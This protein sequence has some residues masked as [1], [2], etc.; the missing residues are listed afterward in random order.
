MP[1]ERAEGLISVEDLGDAM[2]LRVGAQAPLSWTGRYAAEHGWA[3]LD[4]GVGLPGT[5]GGATVNNA[6]A[7]GTE[8]KDHLER[9][10]L[11]SLDGTLREEPAAWLEAEYR[12]TRIKVQPRPRS[13]IVV[14]SVFLLPKGDREALLALADDHARFRR[15]TQPTGACSGSVFANPPGDYAG[16]LLEEAGLKGYR[17]A[18]ARFS[19]K[20]A[21]WII[22]EDQASA[23][24]VRALI[25]HAQ[26]TIRE[27]F[28]IDL[29][30]EV[31]QLRSQ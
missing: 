15:E 28:G 5:I 13:E 25:A 9:V 4:W 11:L 23:E 10:V 8:L 2:R 30:P 17:I 19:P 16:R 14:E 1:G 6:G 22:N 21:N 27:R 26:A 20:H 24:D 12:R 18:G 29:R 3:G 7:H 31:E